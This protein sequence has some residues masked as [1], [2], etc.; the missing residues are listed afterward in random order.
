M[1]E[2]VR[3]SWICVFV[4]VEENEQQEGYVRPAM[5]SLFFHVLR[6]TKTSSVRQSSL[7]WEGSSGTSPYWSIPIGNVQFRK[8]SRAY[9]SVRSAGKVNC[10]HL[11]CPC[12]HMRIREPLLNARTW[13]RSGVIGTARAKRRWPMGGSAYGM[14][15]KLR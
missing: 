14:L 13:R 5:W 4:N 2:S 11:T 9:R 6:G 12:G 1:Y 15:L 8:S 3:G 7:I 10:P